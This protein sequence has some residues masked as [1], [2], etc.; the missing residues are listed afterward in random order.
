MKRIKTT[1]TF[2]QIL[3]KL[4]HVPTEE[5]S[6]VIPLPIAHLTSSRSFEKILEGSAFQPQ[7][8]NVFQC[9]LLYFSYGGI[10][11]RYGEQPT[12]ET[13]KLPV[14]FVFKPTLLRNIDY[15][16]PYDTG[17]AN[18]NLYNNQ[19]MQ[20][21]AN[22]RVSNN[23]G[24]EL[25]SK[26]VYYFYHSNEKYLKGKAVQE[27][28][29][30]SLPLMEPMQKL[31]NFLQSDLCQFDVDHRQRAIE[32]Q[33]RQEISLKKVIQDILW[34]G[35][36]D[37]MRNKFYEMCY[38]NGKPNYVPQCYFYQYY[39]ARSPSSIADCLEDKARE[40]VFERHLWY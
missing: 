2:D 5:E 21:F 37:L 10:F 26:I 1:T 4:P 20:N 28:N 12:Q 14:A 18:K 27:F 40:A 23:R 3:K 17:A 22:Y 8:C 35:F 31:L 38:V 36:P 11:H 33:S 9:D 16:F 7:F 30:L 24:S 39:K 34:V 29:K 13:T 15:L 19:E 32:C 25:A 6:K